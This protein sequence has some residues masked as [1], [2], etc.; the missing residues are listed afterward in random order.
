ME[1]LHTS[2]GEL[3]RLSELNMDDQRSVLELVDG[4]RHRTVASALGA[5][6]GPVTEPSPDTALKETRKRHLQG[7]VATIDSLRARIVEIRDEPGGQPN[8]RYDQQALDALDEA[9]KALAKWG[10]K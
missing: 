1:G 9:R 7:M 5:W 2:D 10:R 3:R 4:E 6:A 8:P